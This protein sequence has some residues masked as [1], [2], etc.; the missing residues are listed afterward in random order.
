V[1]LG[2]NVGANS[3]DEVTHKPA[4]PNE[5]EA[6][7]EM[8]KVPPKFNFRGDST[9]VDYCLDLLRSI[10]RSRLVNLATETNPFRSDVPVMKTLSAEHRELLLDVLIYHQPT[11]TSGCICGGVELGKS[12]PEHVVEIFETRMR[13]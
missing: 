12:H 9:L 13:T 3:G 6:L 11:N 4:T 8:L 7:Y 2:L 10:P 5:H 1:K